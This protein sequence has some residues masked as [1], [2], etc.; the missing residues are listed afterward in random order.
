MATIYLSS[1]YE[2]LKEYRTVVF[3]ALRKAG[4]QVDGMEDCVAADQRPVDKCLKDVEKAEIYIGLFAFRYGYTPPAEHNNPNGLSITELEY[5]RAEVLGKPRLAFLA[6]DDAGIPLKHVDA[7]TGDGQKG[8]RI[9]DLRQHLLTE[10]LASEFSEPH[11]LSALVLAAVAKHLAETHQPEPVNVQQ[12]DDAPA[13][14]WHIETQDSPYPGLDHFTKKYA[15]VFFG[16]EA[17]VRAILDRMRGPN[18]RFVIVS[19]DSGTGKSSVIHAGVVPKI[20]Q[21]G[22]GDHKRVLCIRMLPSQGRHPFAAL[23]NAL[24]PFATEAGLKPDDVAEELAHAPAQLGETIHTILAKGT[25]SHALVLFL[26]Q[27]E[28]LFTAHTPHATQEFLRVLC[29]AT[30]GGPLWVLATIRSDHLHHCHNHPDMLTILRGPG[31]YPLGPIEPFMVED[32]IAKPARCAGLTI[33]DKLVRRIV[34]E[35][36]TKVDDY[37]R[38]DQ[39]NLPLLAFVLRELFEKRWDH[40]LSENA[41]NQIGGVAGAVA[42]HAAGVEAEL[43]RTQG[44]KTDALLPKVFD[45]LIIQ[46]EVGPPT[47]RRPLKADLS[48][49]LRGAVE[50]LVQRRLLRTEGE[51][52][53]A[54]VSISHEKLF[55]A[56]PSLKDYVDKNKKQ[57]IDRTILEHRAKKWAEEGRSWHSGLAS[58][59]ED[60]EYCQAGIGLT[61]EMKEYLRVSRRARQVFSMALAAVALLVLGTTWLWQKGYNLEQAGLKVQSLVVSIHVPPQMVEIPGG[62]FQMGDVENL[63][64]PWRNPVHP[65][66]I[67]PFR[68][69]THEV[70]FEEYDRFA[71]ATGR[72]LPEDQGWGRD[73]R[74]VINVS[75]DDATAYA[76]RLSAQTGQRYRYRL[77][78]ESEWEY[79]A[80]SGAKQE[81]WAGTSEESELEKYAVFAQNS[82]GRTAE[83][84][85]KQA[86]EVGLHDLSGNVWEWV[87]DCVHA[88]Y[89]GAPKDGSA[90]L[91]ANGGN[92]GGRVIRGGSWDFDPVYLRASLR[93]RFIAGDRLSLIG[94][95]LAQDL[96]P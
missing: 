80:R 95:R 88:T 34:H 51:G 15:P 29:Q 9:R 70:T 82:G 71:I 87:E 86:N 73:K 12:S 81:A 62:T 92:C 75:W 25:Q 76:D 69:G 77:P 18:G 57:L 67:R 79:A 21:L 4:H 39:T 40:E 27:M 26:D 11:Q 72:R 59:R 42:K 48:S 63:G 33:S 20:E 96:K 14:T 65:A 16:R 43:E 24:N 46:N 94:F 32:L 41:Y 93:L 84:G 78:T 61:E 2:D 90:W 31:H 1:T 36:L 54:T 74:P 5:R 83:V 55:E 13:I 56:W 38:S 3:E 8:E 50:V 58:A 23:M 44:V 10:K 52:D 37:A 47:R 45:S 6:K 30:Q 85:S 89:E 28:E 68:L 19:G 17:E 53:Q 64:E 22:L 7:Y 60:Q 66:T 49:E 35:T 91:E